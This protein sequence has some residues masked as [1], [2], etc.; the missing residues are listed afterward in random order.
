MCSLHTASVS[1]DSLEESMAQLKFTTFEI[2]SAALLLVMATSSAKADTLALGASA[3]GYFSASVSSTQTLAQEFLVYNTFHAGWVSLFMS[4][5]GVGYDFTAELTDE[6]GPQ[7]DVSNVMWQTT[8][9]FPNT[10]GA[11]PVGSGAW[12]SFPVNIDLNPGG[13]YFVL[14]SKQP[15][16]E[17]GWVAAMPSTVANTTLGAVTSAYV[18]STVV[19]VLPSALNYQPLNIITYENG[20]PYNTPYLFRLGAAGTDGQPPTQGEPSSPPPPL[21]PQFIGA[22]NGAQPSAAPEPGTWMMGAAGA[23]LIGAGAWRKRKRG[24]A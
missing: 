5:Y 21:P 23:L 13:Y 22:F 24:S 4:G 7:A 12:L 10:G 9:L 2:T 19:G 20:E 3:P 14:S 1:Q 17:Q 11:L 18:A 6:I 8:G 15:Y 16:D